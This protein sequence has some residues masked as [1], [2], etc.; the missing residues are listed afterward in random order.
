MIGKSK[1][2]ILAIISATS[3][4]LCLGALPATLPT[5]KSKSGFQTTPHSTQQNVTT[6]KSDVF[7]TGKPFE[8][9]REGYL[10]K[11]RS[12]SPELSRWT[13]SDPSGFSDD[14]NNQRYCSV[15]TNSLDVGGLFDWSLFDVT[16][17]DSQGLG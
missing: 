17:F 14:P 13:S 12:Y 6:V 5:F 4:Q 9:N 2:I 10:F 16:K 3:S 15:P 8:V 11:Y 1:F 7:Y